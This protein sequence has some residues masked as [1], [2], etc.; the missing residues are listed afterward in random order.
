LTH[1]LINKSKALAVSVPSQ[2]AP[3]SFIGHFGFKSGRDINKLEGV[4]PEIGETQ[5]P[6]VS[7]NDIPYLKAGLVLEVDEGTQTIFKEGEPMTSANYYQ[8]KRGTI[9][10][11]APIYIEERK[12]A[13]L[14]MTKIRM[15]RSWLYL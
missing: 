5:A 15:Y 11:T 9:P 7:D 3:L 2:H 1:E 14:E 4:N 10:K 6:V 8:V 13:K 12:E